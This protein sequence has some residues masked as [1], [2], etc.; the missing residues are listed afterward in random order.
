MTYTWDANGNLLSDGI[1]TFT[2]DNVNRLITVTNGTTLTLEYQY[3]GDGVLVAQTA[4]GVETTFV[5][6]VGG[7]LS[8]ILVE[9]SGGS[10]EWHL[11]GLAGVLAWTED[12]AWVYPLKDA[13]GSPALSKVEGVRQLL[14]LPLDFSSLQVT[15]PPQ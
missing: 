3:N 5:Q 6:D 4:D 1:F 8:Q 7:P 15:I 11:Y 9:T 14:S 12:G 10:T 13:L 2:Y